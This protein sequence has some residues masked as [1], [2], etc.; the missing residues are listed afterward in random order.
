MKLTSDQIKT[1]INKLEYTF[2]HSE[3]GKKA[4]SELSSDL[5]K[6]QLNLLIKKL[7]YR[8]KNNDKGKKFIQSVVDIFPKPL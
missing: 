7:E 8:Y 1:F 6:D 3:N 2:K 5:T 4:I